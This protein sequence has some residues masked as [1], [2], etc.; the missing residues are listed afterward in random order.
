[1]K[2]II[3]VVGLLSLFGC[4]SADITDSQVK[5]VAENCTA[6]HMIVLLTKTSNGNKISCQEAVT[7]TTDESV[8][9]E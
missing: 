6:N 7:E 9:S 3:L 2:K 8:E 4:S 1:M 5:S